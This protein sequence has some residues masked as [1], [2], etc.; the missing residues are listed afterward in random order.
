KTILKCKAGY[1]RIPAELL[2]V[3]VFMRVEDGEGTKGLMVVQKAVDA[4]DGSVPSASR[5]PVAPHAKRCDPEVALQLVADAAAYD[6]PMSA[7]MLV[8]FVNK[9]IGKVP[10]RCRAKLCPVVFDRSKQDDA[11]DV[12]LSFDVGAD[13]GAIPARFIHEMQ[14]GDIAVN[15]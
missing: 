11:R 4:L 6:E 3:L 7:A 1:P 13:P 12:H 10:F 2:H 9:G 5:L 14:I 15:R 8:E